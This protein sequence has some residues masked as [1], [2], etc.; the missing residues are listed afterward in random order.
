MRLLIA[1]LTLIL[2]LPS[3]AH[4]SSISFEID[5]GGRNVDCR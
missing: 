4:P 2:S 5:G 3:L 1:A